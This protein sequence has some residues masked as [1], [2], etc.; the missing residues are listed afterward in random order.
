MSAVAKGNGPTYGLGKD[1]PQS[2]GHV[3]T[4]TSSAVATTT[5]KLVPFAISRLDA[6]RLRQAELNAATTHL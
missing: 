1:E 6:H 3:R 2:M 5:T 4:A